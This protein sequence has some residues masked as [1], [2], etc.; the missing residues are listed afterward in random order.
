MSVHIRGKEYGGLWTEDDKGDLIVLPELLSDALDLAANDMDSL[1][2]DLY[3]PKWDVF[4]SGARD[5][6]KCVV[7]HA[8]AV[9]A[10]TLGIKR[11]F[12]CEP[13]VFSFMEY[14]YESALRGIDVAIRRFDIPRGVLALQGYGRSHNRWGGEIL[15]HPLLSVGDLIGNM[16]GDATAEQ[17]ALVEKWAGRAESAAYETAEYRDWAGADAHN[18]VV[19]ELASD[20]RSAGW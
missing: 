11:S 16:I 7:N 18:E 1:D 2:R 20:L 6:D 10:A 9:M 4:H 14:W 3:A 13:W 19:R 15:E 8:G 12:D 17:A 5:G